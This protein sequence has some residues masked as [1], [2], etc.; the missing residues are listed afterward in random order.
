MGNRIALW[1]NLKF[2]LVTCVVIGHFADQFTNVSKIYD[3]IFLFIYS[4]HIPLFIF[5]AGLMFKNR[6]I[7]A[8][9]I[10][11]I[12][13]G[14]SY[15]IVSA[16]VE[17]LLGTVKVE[18][19]LLWDGGLSWF[20][21]ALAAYIVILKIIEKQNKEYIL[22]F[23]IV[24]ACFV[25]YDPGIGDFLYLSRIIIFFPFFLSGVL[26]QNF[27]IVSFKDKNF[28]YKFLAGLIVLVWLGLCIYEVDR[29]YGLRYLFTGRNPFFPRIMS[30]APLVRLASYIISFSMGFSLVMLMPNRRMFLITDMGKN[31][32][33][34]YFWH[35]HIYYILNKVFNISNVFNYGVSGKLAFLLMA[36]LLSM[37]LSHKI[38]SFPIRQIREQ[39]F[40]NKKA[41]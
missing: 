9:A 19:F 6:N 35:M 38:F 37:I 2:F 8:K 36:V 7:T 39:I 40:F 41:S 28:K 17:R 18:F 4:F 30:Y 25:G 33:N 34:V 23:S 15:K 11:Y 20:M 12:S 16:I 14:F 24:L 31:S 29:V 10:F 32:I 3:S 13:I 21:F 26:L 5:I 1:D 27:D 22:V